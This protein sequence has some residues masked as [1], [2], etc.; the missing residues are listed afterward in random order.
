MHPGALKQGNLCHAA[1]HLQAGGTILK[2]SD[3]AA[4][5]VSKMDEN[6]IVPP[7]DEEARARQKLQ[8]RLVSMGV[9]LVILAIPVG[10]GAYRVWRFHQAVNE[11]QKLAEAELKKP[12]PRSEAFGSLGSIYLDQGRVAEALPLLEKAAAIELA[13]K[14]GTQDH[15]TLAKAYLMGSQN[16]IAD[17]TQAKAAEALQQSIAL[18]Q[19]L[20]Q[21]RQAAT[22]F[23]AGVFYRQMGRKDEALKALDKAVTLQPDDWVDEG[24]GVRYKKSGL[25]SYYQKMLAAAQLD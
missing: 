16:G 25:A 4:K 17:A 6:R 2:I 22:Y 13:G 21:G 5:E 10:I 20:S 14:T 7:F 12:Q 19:G 24:K 18:A 15:L 3:L 8:R 1:E 23:S 9:F 11:E